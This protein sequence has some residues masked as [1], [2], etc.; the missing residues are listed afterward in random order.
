MLH[1]AGISV[2]CIAFI[3]NHGFNMTGDWQPKLMRTTHT[4]ISTLQHAVELF[5]MLETSSM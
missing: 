2:S 3:A 4:N 5:G 1:G